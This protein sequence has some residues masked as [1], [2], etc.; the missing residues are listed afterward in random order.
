MI[1]KLIIALILIHGY[2]SAQINDGYSWKTDELKGNVKSIHEVRTIKDTLETEGDFLQES[3]YNEEGKLVKRTH[4]QIGYYLETTKYDF[5]DNALLKEVEMIEEGTHTRYQYF[6]TSYNRLLSIKEIEVQGETDV[7]ITSTE[8]DY[9]DQNQAMLSTLLDAKGAVLSSTQSFLDSHLNDTLVVQLDAK[10]TVLEKEIRRFDNQD[11]RI[12][13]KSVKDGIVDWRM[14]VSYPNDT[15]IVT[16]TTDQ[17]GTSSDYTEKVFFSNGNL[18]HM[19][20]EGMFNARL[21]Y[22]YTYDYDEQGNWIKRMGYKDGKLVFVYKREI[23]YY[24]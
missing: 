19:K 3:F 5:G 11:R 12:F 13:S 6:Y 2:A 4:E 21:D 23:E 7:L 18:A 9:H 16:E 17:V 10:G 15:T 22:N 24:E 8:Y 1:R 14:N 20:V